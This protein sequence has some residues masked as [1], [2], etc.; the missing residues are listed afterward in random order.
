M[1]TN[2]H[3][4]SYSLEIYKIIQE[5]LQ[6]LCDDWVRAWEY[7][8]YRGAVNVRVDFKEEKIIFDA[9]IVDGIPWIGH[10]ID[11]KYID[12]DSTLICD[13]KE[14]YKSYQNERIQKS[15]TLHSLEQ[16]PNVREYIKLTQFR[17][18]NIFY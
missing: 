18:T 8:G 12:D 13:S 2:S 7:S 15:K 16:D 3:N 17:P 9:W 11:L 14:W 1:K 5:K 10:R 6:K 4:L